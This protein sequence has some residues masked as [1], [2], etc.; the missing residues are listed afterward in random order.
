MKKQIIL[1]KGKIELLTPALI[2]SGRAETTEMDVILDS[3]QKPFIPAT[4]LLGSLKRHIKLAG[5]DKETSKCG[6]LF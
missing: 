3:D 6:H 2:G 4:S 5:K 1:A